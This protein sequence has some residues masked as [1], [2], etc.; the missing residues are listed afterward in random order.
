MSGAN[1]IHD[2]GYRESGLRGSY[3]MLVMSNE[4][5]SMVKRILRGVV[6]DAEHLAL[7]AIG[8]VGPGGTA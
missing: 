5:I 1:L 8:R 7:D 6:V 4:I 3:D 2:M